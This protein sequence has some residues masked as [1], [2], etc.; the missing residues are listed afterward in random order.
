MDGRLKTRQGFTLMELLIVMGLMVLLMGLAITTFTHGRA[1]AMR[2]AV[3]NVRSALVFARQQAITQRTPTTLI[4]GHEEIGRSQ[5]M[6]SFYAVTNGADGL[7]MTTN[8]LPDGIVFTNL[9]TS[10]GRTVYSA[11]T[12]RP[13]GSVDGDAMGHQF[14]M[15]EEYGSAQSVAFDFK[16]LSLTGIVKVQERVRSVQ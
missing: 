16:V 4:V 5:I 6:R 7:V 9:A 10:A 12:F 13:D 1:E 11:L 15:T 2:G 8:Y 14:G 3:I